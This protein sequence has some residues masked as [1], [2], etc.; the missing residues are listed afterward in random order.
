MQQCAPTVDLA[1]CTLRRDYGETSPRDTVH[2]L[3]LISHVGRHRQAISLFAETS[4]ISILG[5]LCTGPDIGIGIRHRH[6]WS[7]LTRW[8]GRNSGPRKWAPRDACVEARIYER[9]SQQESTC[10]WCV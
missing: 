9:P 8:S 1:T 2:V 4:S 6:L 10:M 5:G 7:K 3:S